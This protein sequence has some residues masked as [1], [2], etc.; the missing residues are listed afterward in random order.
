MKRNVA[1][2]IWLDEHGV[3]SAQHLAEISG[4]T[5]EELD[6][7]IESGVIVPFDDTAVSM[8]FHLRYVVTANIAR[9]LRDDFELDRTGV[10]LAMTL[11]RRIDELQEELNALRARFDHANLCQD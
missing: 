9:R 10:A 5:H 1:E 3:C 4:L 2:S 6:G 8:S 7:L 11:I